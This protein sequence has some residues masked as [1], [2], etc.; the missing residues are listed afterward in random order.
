MKIGTL[1]RYHEIDSHSQEAFIITELPMHGCSFKIS[2]GTKLILAPP[3]STLVAFVAGS[4][5]AQR[6]PKTAA[7]HMSG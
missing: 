2:Y 5:L 6:R 1:E 7:R 4:I 3:D